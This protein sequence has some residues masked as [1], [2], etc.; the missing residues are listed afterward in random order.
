MIVEMRRY[1]ESLSR[2]LGAWT[3]E[4]ETETERQKTKT[5]TEETGK[6]LPTQSVHSSRWMKRH[7]RESHNSFPAKY[8]LALLQYLRTY[9][10]RYDTIS[11]VKAS[12]PSFICYGTP[13]VARSLPSVGEEPSIHL[14]YRVPSSGIRRR[15]ARYLPTG[16]LNSTGDS[17]LAPSPFTMCLLIVE[18][19]TEG[20]RPVRSYMADNGERLGSR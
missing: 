1:Y 5:E 7:L 10:I 8:V 13:I 19:Q 4:T 15:K 17:Y 3:G 16:R 18:A 14:R 9:A 11:G 6:R 20:L 2:P 12:A